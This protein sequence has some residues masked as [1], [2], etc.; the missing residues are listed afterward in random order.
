MNG[1]FMYLETDAF[2]SITDVS[3]FFLNIAC[4]LCSYFLLFNDFW[5]AANIKKKSPKH[6]KMFQ[7][8]LFRSTKR[9]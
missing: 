4:C 6:K 3:L 5:I 2:F 7:K 8:P 9:L 1:N